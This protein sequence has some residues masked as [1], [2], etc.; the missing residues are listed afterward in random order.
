MSNALFTVPPLVTQNIARAKGYLRRNEVLRAIEC[1]ISAAEIFQPQK[2]MG[3]GRFETEVHL[4]ESVEE[5]SREPTVAAFLQSL[6]KGKPP[7]ISYVSGGEEK[8]AATLKVIHKVLKERLEEQATQACESIEARRES[9]WEQGVAALAEGQAP[10]GKGILRRLGD[11]FGDEPD[12]LTNIGE[13]LLNAKLLFEAADFLEASMD[14]F[15]KDSKAFSLLIKCRMELREYEK[16]E[17][18]YQK[19]LKQFGPHPATLL[20]FA[21]LYRA[22]GKRDSAYDMAVRAL[23]A[24]PDNPEIQELLEWSEGRG[25]GR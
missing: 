13:A 8:L 25:R 24:D 9:L 7:V 10:K 16:V 3:K 19:A 14:K 1:L 18:L 17:A 12:V 20:N 4:Q 5:L 6:S 15:P 11:E 2:V 22:W 23:K 21:K